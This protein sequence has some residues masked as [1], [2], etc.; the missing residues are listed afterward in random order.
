MQNQQ[1][2]H[3][4]VNLHI[5]SPIHIG[6]GQELDPFSYVIRGKGLF[7][8]DLVKWMENYPE[9]DKLES[10]MDSDNFAVI[11]SFIAEQFNLESAVRCSIPVDNP[12]LL[13]TY[14]KAIK[15]RNLRN[16]V[17]ISPT[18]RNE[19]SMDAYIP[20][21]SIKGAMRTAIANRFVE[22]AGVTKKDSRGRN[23]Y[24][25]KI[26]GQINK[27]PMRRLKISDVP[28]GKSNTVV[29]E[30][31][32]YPLNPNK[33]LT[34][35]GHMETT[36]SLSHTD[37]PFVYPLRLSL[38]PFELHGAKVD[39]NFIV[40]SLYRFYVPKYEEEYSKFY[41]PQD[42]QAVQQGIIPMNKV[43]ANLRTNETLIRIG[44]F[45][46]VECITLDKV[47]DPKTRMGRGRRPLPWGTTRTLANGIYPFGWA[48]LEFLDLGARPR[49]PKD[50]PFLLE[51]RE[52]GVKKFVP[53]APE[54]EAKDDQIQP[55]D[56]ADEEDRRKRD[57]PAKKV[58]PVVVETISPLEKLIKELELIK[59]NDMGRIGTVIQKI[60]TL[61]TDAEKGKIAKAIR[62][63]IGPKAFKKHK[64]KEY[65]LD[66]I[67]KAEQ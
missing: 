65:L 61:E 38:A 62:D 24:N 11:R 63:K 17:L 12:E 21:S 52:E 41:Q 51:S 57:I 60:D 14:K 34:P 4:S 28:L 5:L 67:D 53:E 19:I 7:L 55:K 10:M 39:P 49:P 23:D 22:P 58:K 6:T 47:R 36:L 13:G 54:F 35:K 40:D 43:V 46:H 29:V 18:I 15:E 25:F 16:Q 50:W 33:S 3:Y 56:D 44:H 59:A 26:F 31:K 37:K 32:E 45:S 66:L 1:L 64:R 27:D 8:I 2:S 30:A 9:K 20:G 48:K 42:S